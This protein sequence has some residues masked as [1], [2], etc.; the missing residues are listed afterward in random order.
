[1]IALKLIL[2]LDSNW[3]II[4][5]KVLPLREGGKKEQ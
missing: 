5:K 1:M 2:K 4:C 3:F